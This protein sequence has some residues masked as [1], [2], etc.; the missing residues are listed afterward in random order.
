MF[1]GTGIGAED[2]LGIT[3]LFKAE[4]LS[5]VMYARPPGPSWASGASLIG[6][7]E[8]TRL[9]S[10]ESMHNPFLFFPMGSGDLNSCPY[11]V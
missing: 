6:R 1:C 8:V 3:I 4:S 11:I 5:V 2:N 10:H 9:K 7:A